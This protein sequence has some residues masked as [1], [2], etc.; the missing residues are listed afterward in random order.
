MGVMYRLA[1]GKQSGWSTTPYTGKQPFVIRGVATKPF[2]LIVRADGFT[3]ASVEGA[4]VGA[5]ETRDLVVTL[6]TGNIL[7]GTLVNAKGNPRAD[8]RLRI[9]THGFGTIQAGNTVTDRKGS[10]TMQGLGSGLVQFNVDS[11]PWFA[12]RPQNGI[13]SFLS[14]SGQSLGIRLVGTPR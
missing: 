11:S 6:G 13:P 7:R 1:R 5:G 4:A 8:V 9:W 10:F 3:E 12:L 14:A 2:K